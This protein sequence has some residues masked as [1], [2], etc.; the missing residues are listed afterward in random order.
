MAITSRHS[1]LVEPGQECAGETK[2]GRAW[3]QREGGRNYPDER[4][5]DERPPPGERNAGGADKAECDDSDPRE[6]EPLAIAQQHIQLSEG[7]SKNDARK[8]T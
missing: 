6:R 2:C 3:A 7:F 4:D 5:R 8:A 1:W